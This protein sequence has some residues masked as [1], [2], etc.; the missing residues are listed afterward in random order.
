MKSMKKI[1]FILCLGVIPALLSG[2]ASIVAKND[3]VVTISTEPDG[4]EV[5]IK[6]SKGRVV[7]KALSPTNVTLLTSDG[8]FSGETY[9]VSLRK[10]GY[11][12][13]DLVIDSTPRGWY[14]FGNLAFG[15]LIG[16]F[17][18]DPA[19]GAMYKLK[20]EEVN[21]MLEPRIKQ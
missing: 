18:V 1:I 16:W 3:Q 10:D 21:V 20:P 4:A 11:S 2:C 19:T 8:F 6:N 14:L 13:K 15:G 17:I 5:V 12:G 9:S 7:H